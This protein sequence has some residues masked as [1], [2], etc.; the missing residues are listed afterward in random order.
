VAN[1]KALSWLWQEETEDSHKN[2][3]VGI[4]DDTTK[5]QTEYFKMTVLE[6]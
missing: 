2:I 1:F 5:I 3:S 6:R 4:V